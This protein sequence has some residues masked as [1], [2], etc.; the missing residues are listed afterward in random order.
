MRFLLFAFFIASGLR[1]FPQQTSIDSL[2]AIVQ[3]GKGDAQTFSALKKLG[4]LTEKD[5]PVKATAYYHRAL[6][7][8]FRSSYAKDFIAVSIDLANLYQIHGRYD[9]SFLLGRQALTLAR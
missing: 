6:A 7:F 5:E 1:C 9:S 3:Q 2:L 4:N 8:P